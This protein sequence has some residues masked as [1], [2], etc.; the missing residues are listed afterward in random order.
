MRKTRPFNP[1]TVKT[2]RLGLMNK[3]DGVDVRSSVVRLT[4]SFGA[5]RCFDAF[6]HFSICLPSYCF[7][8]G[9]FKGRVSR[10]DKYSGVSSNET[11]TAA[12]HGRDYCVTRPCIQCNS[13]VKT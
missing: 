5:S 4:K 2:A 3:V 7:Y 6:A 10:L 12:T 8:G 1:K 11:A 9:D 13:G